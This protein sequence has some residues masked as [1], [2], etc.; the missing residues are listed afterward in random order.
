LNAS[1]AALMAL[2]DLFSPPITAS[3]V[4]RWIGFAAPC[5]GSEAQTW[6]VGGSVSRIVAPAD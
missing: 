1:A 4:G 5:F 3:P 6:A 2:L